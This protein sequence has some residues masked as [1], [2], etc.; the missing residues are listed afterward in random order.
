MSSLSFRAAFCLSLALL[1]GLPITGQAQVKPQDVSFETAD[2][3]DLQGMFYPSKNGGGSASVI[4]MHSLYKDPKKGDWAGLAKT[5]AE[6]GFNVLRFD[7][8]GHGGSTE[9][10]DKKLFWSTP[11]N[12]KVMAAQAAKGSKVI[13]YKNFQG[14]AGYFPMLANDLMA[15]RVALD[16]KN[17]GN[18]TNT[19]SVYII[20]PED[21]ITLGMIYLAAEWTRPNILQQGAAVNYLPWN[22][23][24]WA[25][26]AEE[27]G[28]D[29]AACVWLS[30]KRD[31]SV[32]QDV[33]KKLAVN[34]PKM[35][36]ENPMLF[37]HGAQ[38][39]AGANSSKFFMN[40]VLV[41]KPAPTTKLEAL[42]YTLTMDVPKSKN[43]GVDLL[44]NS[45]GTEKMIV[46]YLKRIEADRKN[47]LPK[48]R[49]YSK[50]PIIDM[51]SYGI[52]G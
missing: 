31:P 8:R 3:V 39:I 33:M 13:D 32:S 48:Q 43:I 51:A 44:G 37:I 1:A 36:E 29:I 16:M 46:D 4:I 34:A 6:E 19:S 52:G 20:G 17:D 26:A 25:P 42:K 45:L 23:Q 9:L 30:P 35:R 24:L 28:K 49:F 12:A 47:R 2:G 18:T 38:D 14:K 27:A 10:K 22:K 41:A 5:L 7:F 11:I 15:A 40:E 50:P 21:T